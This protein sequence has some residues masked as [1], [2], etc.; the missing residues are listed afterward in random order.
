MRKNLKQ[1]LSVLI[2]CT[3]CFQFWFVVPEAI[4]GILLDICGYGLQFS[5][6][7]NLCQK[8]FGGV[9]FPLAQQTPAGQ[10]ENTH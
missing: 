5:K 8:C 3:L 7:N 2:V 10:P 6:E 9:F 4:G 1:M